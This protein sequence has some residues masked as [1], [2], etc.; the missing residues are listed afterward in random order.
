MEDRRRHASCEHSAISGH[1]DWHAHHPREG[2][3]RQLIVRRPIVRVR[4]KRY[5]VNE[6]G[7]S[8]D[9]FLI[10]A[11]CFVLAC[12]LIALFRPVALGI[13]WYIDDPY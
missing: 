9:F 6:N 3:R 13:L 12:L 4:R 10:M 2:E 11:L 5:I 7:I 1:R 8:R